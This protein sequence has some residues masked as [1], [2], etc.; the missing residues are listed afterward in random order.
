MDSNPFSPLS[1]RTMAHEEESIDWSNIKTVHE[2][3]IEEKPRTNF[4]L[5][6]LH[7]EA[8]HRLQ[9]L[10]FVKLDEN[11][12]QQEVSDE[13]IDTILLKRRHLEDPDLLADRY[14]M[15]HG[16]YEIFK[17]VSTFDSWKQS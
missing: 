7:P 17:V 10:G 3:Q 14:M 4:D 8:R 1:D 6:N 5:E 11:G 15:K 2:E 9:M 13:E 12:I 16:V